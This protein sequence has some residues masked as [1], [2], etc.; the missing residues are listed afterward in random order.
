MSAE[1]PQTSKP[2]SQYPSRRGD[3]PG[4]PIVF[5]KIEPYEDHVIGFA[6]YTDPQGFG[7]FD[8]RV[9]GSEAGIRS[10]AA[11][12][13]IVKLQIV[14]HRQLDGRAANEQR[15]TAADY[16][17]TVWQQRMARLHKV[18]DEAGVEWLADPDR[19]WQ[20]CRDVERAETGFHTLPNWDRDRL[21]R[22]EPT[23]GLVEG[24]AYW[25]DMVVDPGLDNFRSDYYSLWSPGFWWWPAVLSGSIAAA[26]QAVFSEGRTDSFLVVRET[27]GGHAEYT[28]VVNGVYYR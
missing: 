7:E 6:R 8:I 28:I 10:Y 3:K 13:H 21:I 11:E 12:A 26:E 20:K 1:S 25:F 24:E 14:P 23:A 27:A 4:T 15:R 22:V 17:R 5:D 19:L 2:S 16:W 9:S 18:V